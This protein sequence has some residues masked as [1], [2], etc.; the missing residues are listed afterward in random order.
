MSDKNTKPSEA[1][2]ALLGD[3]ETMAKAVP[4]TTAEDPSVEG[5]GDPAEGAPAEGAS[6]EG[7]PAITKSLQVTLADGTVVEAEDGGELVKAL[8]ERVD[9]TES[10]MAK[11]LGI[12]V[13]LIKKQGEQLA[14][15]NSL[16][17]SLQA[18]LAKVAAA[19]AGRKTVLTMHEKPAGTMT[20]SEPEGD[21]PQE[22]MAKALGAQKAGRITGL[23]V[24][25][26][27]ACLNRGISV[28]GHIVSA[29]YR[30]D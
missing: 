12:A 24:S 7:E 3:L 5:E 15:T 14:A 6:T 11:A 1:F 4:E 19:P 8:M 23:D 17:K 16:V 21:S 25:T 9:N 18:D 28:P 27:E 30:K 22:F 13:D 10:T 2:T 29:V 20:K 26:A